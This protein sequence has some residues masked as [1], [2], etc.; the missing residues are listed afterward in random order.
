ML[1]PSS[2]F[3]SEADLRLPD[4][5]S[6]PEAR[7]GAALAKHF[8]D[9]WEDDEALMALLRT[10]VTHEAAAER[11]RSIFAAQLGPVVAS[12]SGAPRATA[13][14]RAGLIATQMLGLA[15]CRYLLK[16]PPVVAM[17]RSE[18]VRQLG[19]TIQ[20]YLFDGE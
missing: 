15:L 6:V 4:L 5:S 13:A 16:L 1:A 3:A 9:R 19:P 8:L 12:L 20:R 2:A 17:K 14:T 10:A 11:M 7:V 18:L